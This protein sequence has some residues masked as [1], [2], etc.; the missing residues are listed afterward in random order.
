M[1][2]SVTPSVNGYVPAISTGFWVAI[3]TN[4]NGTG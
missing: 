4:G 2:R 3:T 1:K